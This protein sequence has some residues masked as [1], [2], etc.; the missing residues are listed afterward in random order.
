MLRHYL[1]EMDVDP[2]L[3]D[4]SIAAGPKENRRLTGKEVG[5]LNLASAPFEMPW[6]TTKNFNN[7]VISK[8]V[9]QERHGEYRTTRIRISCG[10]IPGYLLTYDRHLFSDAKPATMLLRVG[11]L[12]LAFEQRKTEKAEFGYVWLT[13]DLLRKAATEP[14][15]ELVQLVDGEPE[16]GVSK[17]ATIGLKQ[18]LD[19]LEE[20][21]AHGQ[22]SLAV[23]TRTSP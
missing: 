16:A 18:S 15:I 19:E 6:F 5:R 17:F 8:W 10:T 2:A 3:V 4:L 12:E 14:S 21:C 13:R 20:T 23:P 1:A 11:D 22:Q 7:S 9:T